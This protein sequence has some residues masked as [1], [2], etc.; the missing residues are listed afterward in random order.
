MNIIFLQFVWTPYDDVFPEVSADWLC[1]TYVI[2]WDIVEECLP[3]RV[4][5]QFHLVQTIPTVRLSNQ[6]EHKRL[7]DLSRHGSSTRNWSSLM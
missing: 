4:M 2:F 1:N 6:Q 5:R 7:H 3:S